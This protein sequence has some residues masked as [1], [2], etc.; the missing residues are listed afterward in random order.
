MGTRRAILRVCRCSECVTIERQHRDGAPEPRSRRPSG[1]G[2]R[3][4]PAVNSRIVET[5]R[6][7]RSQEVIENKGDRFITNCKAK[8][9]LKTKELF[10]SSQEVTD[11]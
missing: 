2:R 9:Y 5:Q 11:N 8:R 6:T 3:N 4:L 10:L 1:G 7:E